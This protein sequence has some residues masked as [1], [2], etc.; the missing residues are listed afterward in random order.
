MGK[1]NGPNTADQLARLFQLRTAGAPGKPHYRTNVF[2]GWV[3]RLLPEIAHLLA[4][5]YF[6]LLYQPVWETEQRRA[7]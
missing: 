4:E 3:Y 5:D 6:R 7:A 1:P 2:V